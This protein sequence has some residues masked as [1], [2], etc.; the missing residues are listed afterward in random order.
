MRRSCLQAQD[1]GSMCQRC[2]TLKRPS[3][4]DFCLGCCNVEWHNLP[5]WLWCSS[6]LAY[7]IAGS[8]LSGELFLP[9][10][11][12]D[13][14]F[15]SL[16]FFFLCRGC[17]LSVMHQEVIRNEETLIICA[18]GRELLTE[19]WAVKLLIQTVARLS[20]CRLEWL[21]T[22]FWFIA[23]N[24]IPWAATQRE[25][26][27]TRSSYNVCFKIQ[28]RFP[29]SIHG[30]G[31]FRCSG[32]QHQGAALWCALEE[33]FRETVGQ[34]VQEVSHSRWGMLRWNTEPKGAGVS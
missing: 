17:V 19:C 33:T 18:S 15:S 1:F 32:H 7:V 14:W 25:R 2:L 12:P 30:A 13:L 34:M 11:V 9:P 3:R 31:R 5:S 28:L 16:F 29:F 26:V 24:R 22:S 10:C 8:F 20:V 23:F 4:P 21:V 27:R 6:I